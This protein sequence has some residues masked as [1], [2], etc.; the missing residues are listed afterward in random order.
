MATVLAKLAVEIAANTASFASGLEKASAQARKF[1]KQIKTVGAAVLG[2]IAFK[3]IGQ[4]IIS[5]TTQ[6]EKFAAVLQN[7]LGSRS[8]AQQAL[9]NI[10]KFASETPFEVAEITAAYVKWTNQG[11][12]PSIEK[13]RMLGDVASSLGA[14]FEQTAEAFKDL[15]VGQTKRIEEIGIAAQQANGKIQ[16]SFKGVTLEIEKN[17]QG[18]DLAL[19][20]Y[21][22]LPGVLGTAAAIAATMGGKIS[23]L[24]DN[25]SILAATIGD[26][27]SGLINGFLD[28]ANNALGSLNNALNKQTDALNEEYIELNSL[29]GA[30]TS[31]NISEEARLNLLNELNRKYPDFLKNLNIEKVTNEQLS[32]R[33]EDVNKQFLKKIAFAAAEEKLIEKQKELNAAID[34]EVEALKEAAANKGKTEVRGAE[35]RV[36]DLEAIALK[37]AS[38]AR[39]EQAEIQ[40]ELTDLVN[41]YQKTWQD[42]ASAEMDYFDAKKQSNK[43][44]INAAENTNAQANVEKTNAQIKAKLQIEEIKRNAERLGLLG[45]LNSKIDEISGKELLSKNELSVVKKASDE[46][47]KLVQKWSDFSKIQSGPSLL[48]LTNPFIKGK[49]AL[50]QLNK[51]ADEWS[52]K[53]K[54]FDFMFPDL[55]PEN[56]SKQL[57]AYIES[58]KPAIDANTALRV[59]VDKLNEA[60][61]ASASEGLQNF[62]VG[63]GDVANKQISFGDNLLKAIAG[64]MRQFGDQLIA[65]GVAKIGLDNLFA[66]GIGGPAAIAA[67]VALVAAAGA[68]SKSLA[69]KSQNISS[70]RGGGSSTGFSGQTMNAA[71]SQ[72]NMQIT[73]KLVGSGRDLIAVIN[74][75]SYDNTQ[76]KGG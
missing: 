45:L 75:T 5:V 57:Q 71:S 22:K 4:E 55:K 24:K 1:E 49:E 12:S 26:R 69:K 25:L 18:V 28:F 14:G 21:S 20:T 11:L 10:K 31:A 42:A 53:K 34:D 8:A 17:A 67:G 19:A 35:A 76:R 40:K 72:G 46:V 64:F 6:F 13:M 2:A 61:L 7:A 39:K 43:E 74:N 3:E 15:A 73:G 63:L 38:E 44:S 51:K 37:K 33:L 56:I 70:G 54:V 41:R 58:T 47:E 52:E 62:F 48:N 65:L 32:A 16:L 59:S 36:Y 23:N 27:S 68:I 9:N 30:I 60:F 50:E 66:T 29:V